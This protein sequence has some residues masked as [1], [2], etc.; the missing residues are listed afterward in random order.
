MLLSSELN[1]SSKHV[2]GITQCSLA[3]LD[4]GVC[5]SFLVYILR[6]YSVFCRLERI[7]A[8]ILACALLRCRPCCDKTD[9]QAKHA[10]FG[11]IIYGLFAV[12][13]GL[14]ARQFPTPPPSGHRHQPSRASVQASEQDAEE[15]R[16]STNGVPPT[17]PESPISIQIDEGQGHGVEAPSVLLHTGVPAK[18]S[19]KGEEDGRPPFDALSSQ[20]GPK[21]KMLSGHLPSSAEA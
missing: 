12:L 20:E 8:P 21:A 15:V 18:S 10:G 11:L 16:P 17:L 9:C 19:V 4:T 13:C 7:Q 3:A 5:P 6:S 14:Y 2:R 1:P